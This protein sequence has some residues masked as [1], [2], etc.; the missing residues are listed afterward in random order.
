M[1][2]V[3]NKTVGTKMEMKK[4]I[5]QEREEQQLRWYSHIM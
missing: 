2:R 5:L 3:R 1:D 4:D